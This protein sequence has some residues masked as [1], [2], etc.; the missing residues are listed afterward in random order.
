MSFEGLTLQIPA[1]EYRHHYVRTNVRV[2]RYVDD[3]L[4][5]FHGPCKLVAFDARGVPTRPKEVQRLAA[6]EAAKPNH[7]CVPNFV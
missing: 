6:R 2:H 7:E 1:N 4:A 3:T 5:L